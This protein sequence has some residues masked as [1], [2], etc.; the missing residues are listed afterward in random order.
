MTLRLYNT[1]TR[2]I[3]PFEPLEPGRVSLYTCGPTIYSYAHIGNFRTFLFEDLLRRWLEASGYEVFHIMNLTDV[4]DR[5]IA[6]ASRKGLSLREHVD[7]FARA[8]EED[9]DWLRIKPPTERPRATEYI[10]PM[11]ELIQGL[12]DRGFAYAGEDGSIYFAIARFPAY[13][14]LSQLDRRE[15][16]TGASERVRADEYS[17]EDARDFVLWKAAEPEDEAVGAAWDTPFGRGRPGWHIECS[18]MALELVRRR[19]GTDVL[20]IHAGAVDL[21]FPHH[22]NEIAQSCA[23]TARDAFARFWLHGEFLKIGGTKMSKRYGNITTARD[24]REDGIDPGA[25]RLLMFQVHYRKQLDLTD[26]AMASAREGSR[27]LGEFQNRLLGEAGAADSPAL[28]E[29]SERMEREMAEALDDDLNAPRAVAAM[30]AFA[31]AGNAALDAGEAAGPRALAAWRRAEGVLGVTSAVQAVKVGAAVPLGPSD[32]SLAET[33]PAHG[34]D[35][36]R[37]WAIAWAVRRK[38]AKSARNYGE[39]DRIRNVLRGAGWE[40]RD[41]RDGSIEVV[42]TAG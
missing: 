33:P 37:T 25:V 8:F 11:V 17:K 15:L 41:N 16:R 9:R 6:A 22:E 28:L 19:F 3:E 14:R 26:E 38:E 10:G 31:T 42:R 5:T 4:D 32:A 39:A 27:R 35:A 12:L 7:P 34:G 29:A 23:F 20:D 1:L 18:A 21:I 40:V 30:F 24:L 2:R 36:E 13:G